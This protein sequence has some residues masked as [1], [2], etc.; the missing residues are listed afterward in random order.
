MPT[1]EFKPVI[2]SVEKL[3]KVWGTIFRGSISH[4]KEERTFALVMNASSLEKAT[5]IDYFITNVEP[6]KVTPEWI[7]K[8]YSN[9]NWVEVFYREAKGWLGL[10]EYQVRD[11]WS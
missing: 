1:E 3:K 6:S 8:S 4:L 9:R 10:K 11:K 7:V 5:E 2:L